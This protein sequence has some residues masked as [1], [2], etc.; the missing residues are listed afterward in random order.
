[1]D[2]ESLPSN[3][4]SSSY[5][6][7]G[8]GYSEES[9]EALASMR[10]PPT[11]DPYA[12]TSSFNVRN[13][14]LLRPPKSVALPSNICKSSAVNYAS[15]SGGQHSGGSNFGLEG[16]PSGGLKGGPS[17][18]IGGLNGGPISGLNGV[19]AESLS[20][21]AREG[22]NGGPRDGLNG[23]PRE[24]FNGDPSD[25]LN[26]DTRD[27]LNGG[28]RDGIE[29][30]PIGRFGGDIP[31]VCGDP[32][33]LRGCQ[34]SDRIPPASMPS[35]HSMTLP[36]PPS[37]PHM[38]SGVD[39]DQPSAAATFVRRP[40]LYTGFPAG[41]AAAKTQ[42]GGVRYSSVNDRDALYIATGNPRR[43]KMPQR[44]GNSS[45]TVLEH[46]TASG[47]TII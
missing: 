27:G 3:E 23:G 16:G 11:Q 18:F 8:R 13:A 30:G 32:D 2:K 47:T 7:S 41:P 38:Q 4:G 22:P 9:G 43:F 5:T 26:G 34:H 29:G 10:R 42:R 20:A 12:G 24:G 33:G 17:G 1:M 36:H 37:R 40:Q 28:P 39:P 46:F 14:L 21:G 6:D 31:G 35:Q 44:S 15:A 25:S 45:G 19:P